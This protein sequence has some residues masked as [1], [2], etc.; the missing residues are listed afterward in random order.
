[1]TMQF[2]TMKAW[3][4]NYLGA[5]SVAGGFRVVGYADAGIDSAQLKG[6]NRMLQVFVSGGEIPA[7]SSAKCGPVVHDVAFSVELLT[8]CASSVDL[9]VLN[10][11]AATSGEIAAALAASQKAAAIADDDFD[12]FLDIVFNLLM[13][14][15]QQDLGH[16]GEV[17]SRWIKSWKKGSPLNR[18]E[19]VI[20]P[21]TIDFSF[22]VSEEITG[23][24]VITPTPNQAVRVAINASADEVGTPQEGS[25]V[26][27]GG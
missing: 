23:C 14:N 6:S 19:H 7:K 24:A 26:L 13:D 2:R 17:A 10:D 9:S 3:L 18:G 5:H 11:P 20:L 15:E 16:P 8:A 1:M 12:E 25:A 22:R 4:V 21:G 27:A